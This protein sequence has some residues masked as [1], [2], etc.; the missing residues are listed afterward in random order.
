MQY[1]LSPIN[2]SRLRKLPNSFTWLDHN[3]IHGDF[4]KRI[5][6][7][8][9][10]LYLFLL[11]V[12]DRYG[13]SYYSDRAICKRINITNIF[14]ARI[15]LINADLISYCKPM[16]QVLSL[17]VQKPNQ[18]IETHSKVESTTNN[19]NERPATKE[20]V[21]KIFQKFRETL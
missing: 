11:T 13:M 10:T 14:A 2:P 20:E 16:Y 3:L 9:G 18:T 15:E 5:N 6:P 12:G 7:E 8:A 21:A 4:L 1:S 17:E 19:K